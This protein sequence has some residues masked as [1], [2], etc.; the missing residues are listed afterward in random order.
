MTPYKYIV[1]DFDGTLVDS[2]SVF[3]ALYNELADKHGYTRMTEDNLQYLRGLSIPERC[4]FL[5]VP[6]YR[7][8]FMVT[9]VIKKY[10]DAVATLQFN[11]GIAELLQSL[12]ENNIPFAVLSSNSK[13]NITQFFTLKGIVNNDVF[14]SR[15]IFGKHVLINKFLNEKNLKP[16]DILYVGDELRDVIACHKT[17]VKIAWVSWGYDSEASLKNNKPDYIVHNPAGLLKMILFPLEL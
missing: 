6:L 11:E 3:I 9:A 14:C 7:I 2:R 1:F 17:G 8:P 5:N 12:D 15:S 10:S 13:K 16:S 4:K